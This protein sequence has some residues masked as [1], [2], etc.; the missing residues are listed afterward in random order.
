VTLSWI[1]Q[2]IIVIYLLSMAG[3]GLFFA[4]RNKSTD[5][6]FTAGRSHGGL[7]LGLSLVGAS[8]SSVT[9]IALPADTFKTAWLRFLPNLALPVA[10]LFAGRYFV[11][12]YRRTRVTS[13]YEYLE[14]R[15]SPGVRLYAAAM[16]GISQLIRL[17][18]VLF[19]LA[20]VVKSITGLNPT[21]CIIAAGLV[22][23]LYTLV[24][25]LN[26][27][28]WTDAIQTVVLLGGGLVVLAVIILAIPGGIGEVFQSALAA[29]KLSTADLVDGKLTPS[30]WGVDL[31]Q[32]TISMMVF[33][34]LVGWLTEYITN[35]G[36]VQ[37]Y[38]AAKSSAEARRSIWL[39]AGMSI[40][41]WALF[42]F[43]GTALFVFYRHFPDQPAA[44]ML[45]GQRKAEEILPHFLVTRV[46]VG[47]VGIVVAGILAAAMSTLSSCMNAFASVAVVDVYRRVLVRGRGDRHYLIAGWAFTT[48]AGIVMVGGA[49][50][51]VHA[52]TNTMND[53]IV[54]VGAICS[55]GMLSIYLLG[56]LTVRANARSVGVAIAAAIVF[57]LWC[58]LSG[59]GVVPAAIRAPFDLYYSGILGNVLVF[60]AGYGVGCLLPARR[61]V[62]RR[63]T[64]W[65]R[66]DDYE[67]APVDP[68]TLEAKT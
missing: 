9:F 57:S 10:I 40:P 30:P 3:V 14:S 11:P 2:A 31:S 68:S 52:Q 48:L 38:A 56:F 66:T 22:T 34:G 45:D 63:L 51:L 43:I 58:V 50:V 64:I 54:L 24:G 8:I 20:M 32:K 59:W 39:C 62:P 35:Q 1:D 27:V 6:Y 36:V 46:P 12:M 19:L 28:I 42:M 47:I 21:A 16:F 5:E 55:A 53:L 15:F 41:I 60:A 29:G 13:A 37:R 25:G 4:R 26:A 18:V 67:P 23:G 65:D 33:V 7:L 49:L 17:S 44:Q 61:D